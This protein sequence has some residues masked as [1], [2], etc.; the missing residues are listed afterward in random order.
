MSLLGL[1]TPL[2]GTVVGAALAGEPF[3]PGQAVG[4]ALVLTGVLAGQPAVVALVENRHGAAA[5]GRG[6]RRERVPAP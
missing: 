6:V 3:G 5:G 2:T 1:L 4:M